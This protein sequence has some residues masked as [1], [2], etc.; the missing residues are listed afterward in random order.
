MAP[1]GSR[2]SHSVLVAPQLKARLLGE[3]GILVLLPDFVV[4]RLCAR[5][6]LAL[7]CFVSLCI[8]ISE[9]KNGNPRNRNLR[10]SENSNLIPKSEIQNRP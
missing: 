9:C 4:L 2:L 5:F 3:L 1:S 7:V 8:C 10:F 6:L